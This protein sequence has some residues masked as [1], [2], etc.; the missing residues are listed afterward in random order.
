MSLPPWLPFNSTIVRP[1]QGNKLA[2]HFPASASSPLGHIPGLGS[3]SSGPA[4][5]LC[6]GAE[7]VCCHLELSPPAQLPLRGCLHPLSWPN[8]LCAWLSAPSV[9]PKLPMSCPSS[10]GDCLMYPTPT[11][12]S[13]QSFPTAPSPAQPGR[14]EVSL[15]SNPISKSCYDLSIPHCPGLERSSASRWG[16]DRRYLCFP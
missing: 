5:P 8:F 12:G 11:L 2:E 1:M 10:P 9:L 15:S 16:T 13:F 4:R 3:K 14:E 7:F 6:C